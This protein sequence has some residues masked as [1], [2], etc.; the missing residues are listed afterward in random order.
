[1][2]NDGLRLIQS[3]TGCGHTKGKS[4]VSR[5]EAFARIRAAVDAREQGKDIVIMGR[6][7]SLI[8][9]FEEAVYRANEYK[10]LGVDVVFV[11]ALPD[12]PT[13]QKCLQAVDIPMMA[14]STFRTSLPAIA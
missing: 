4:V 12:K 8:L 5:E 14:N 11:E 7:D 9:G 1:L 10:R 13:M 2:R 3:A 6:T